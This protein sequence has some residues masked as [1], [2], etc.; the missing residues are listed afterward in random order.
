MTDP[1]QHTGSLL[2]NASWQ[3]VTFFFLSVVNNIWFIYLG[4]LFSNF[5]F[6]FEIVSNLYFKIQNY[7]K[8][9]VYIVC[10]VL[11]L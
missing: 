11:P 4:L 6:I 8:Q 5:I 1:K 9:S 10:L 3:W 2:L 7:K